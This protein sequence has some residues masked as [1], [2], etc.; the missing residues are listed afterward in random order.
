MSGEASEAIGC[1]IEVKSSQGMQVTKTWSLASRG[2]MLAYLRFSSSMEPASS[3]VA[4]PLATKVRTSSDQSNW[5]K[6]RSQCWFTTVKEGCRRSMRIT[7]PSYT[8]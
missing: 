4:W 7:S 6:F 2:D 3:R 1:W 8:R 5:A